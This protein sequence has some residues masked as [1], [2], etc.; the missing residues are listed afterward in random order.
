MSEPTPPL[1]RITLIGPMRVEHA[2]GAQ[3]S[4]RYEKLKA[5][6][7]YLI[8]H[9][10]QAHPRAEL[11]RLLWPDGTTEAA[12]NNLRRALFDLRK[13]FESLH[14]PCPL[15]SDRRVVQWRTTAEVHVE[16]FQV[17]H[18]DAH[19]V[20]LENVQLD[21]CPAWQQWRQQQREQLRQE[22]LA[23]LDEQVHRCERRG[24]W[25]QAIGFAELRVNASPEHEAGH[26]QL[27]RLL[28]QHGQRARAKVA[29]EACLAMQQRHWGLPL[30]EQTL[31]LGRALQD[32][33]HVVETARVRSPITLLVVHLAAQD[34]DAAGSHWHA[35]RPL[36]GGRLS[37]LSAR[38][39]VVSFGGAAALEHTPQRAW[40]V[41]R[42]QLDLDA[43]QSSATWQAAIA[44]GG[45]VLAPGYPTPD[46]S[47]QV[48]SEALAL[49]F[50]TPMG[51]M[52]LNAAALLMLKRDLPP[53]PPSIG[54]RFQALSAL[55]PLRP[56]ASFC[57][58]M[59]D[60]E[61]SPVG[62][63][64][65]VERLRAWWA[66]GLGQ[67]SRRLH[68]E[69]DGGLGKTRLLRH[70]GAH[71]IGQGGKVLLIQ[72]D[73]LFRHHPW[74]ALKQSVQGQVQDASNRP[75]S[76]RLRR[77]RRAW[78]G[79]L[80]RQAETW[81]G[82]TRLLE[83]PSTLDDPLISA[84]QQRARMEAGLFGLL[85]LWCGDLPLLLIVEDT[86]WL[87]EA[88]WQAVVRL[89]ERANWPRH[90]KVVSSARTGEGQAPTQ[91]QLT[92]L[93][94]T[95]AAANE[96]AHQLVVAAD[97]R[98]PEDTLA[99]L[100]ARA[101]GVPLF[102]EQLIHAHQRA[103]G[104][105]IAPPPTLN[106]LLLTR[107][108]GLGAHLALVQSA[109]CT[110]RTIDLTLLMHQQGT[111]S[112]QLQLGLESLQRAGI[113]QCNGEHWSFR[114]AFIQAAAHASMPD[115]VRRRVHRQLA[116]IM[117]TRTPDR[118]RE[119]PERL[120]QHLHEAGSPDAPAA[121][122]AAARH[123]NRRSEPD[124]AR[125]H[126][127]QGLDALPLLQDEA[128]RQ[129][130]AFRLWVERGHTLVALNG[131]GSE[132]SRGAYATALAMADR[133]SDEGDLFQLMWGLW[134]GSR[135][136]EEQAPPMSFAERLERA[137]RDSTDPGI[138][139]QVN[140]A[141]GNNHFWL[142][143]YPAARGR[144]EAAVALSSRVD[145]TQ[146][147]ALYGEAS[148]VCA[149]A[150][151]SWLDWLEG[152]TEKALWRADDAVA[153]GRRTGH[154][155]TLCFALAFS[156]TLQ[157]Y[158]DRADAAAKQAATLA[159]LASEHRLGLW[160][161]TAAAVAGWAQARSGDPAGLA[162]IRTG[163]A[164]AK[165]AMAAVETTFQAFLA[166]ALVHLRQWDEALLVIDDG[167]R[168][169]HAIPDTYLLP[170]L[171]RL[172]AHAQAALDPPD[173]AACEATLQAAQDIAEAQGAVA[174][175]RKLAL[176]RRV[177]LG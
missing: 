67:G 39:L 166:D 9:P 162:P 6:L 51:H 148:H 32:A 70:L 38:L 171:M 128:T 145:D 129:D 153:R 137:A 14:T 150:F 116:D 66:D 34:P 78:G 104:E 8:C 60:A 7:A 119:A 158:L 98:I 89:S 71:C 26:R 43:G 173:K 29:Y 169:A 140:Y 56:N 125:H 177:L 44:H 52:Q 72:A 127:Q 37:R 174:L 118:I 91:D 46:A 48:L 143:Q 132:S 144:L 149:Q 121:W 160:Q 88:T 136:V 131:Y 135:T 142:A 120:A 83:L 86:H 23:N 146:M 101:E 141:F 50:A 111:S 123:F 170:E 42:R 11:A 31:A 79:A 49:A 134:L 15:S 21:D 85:K 154:A 108:Q 36:L 75:E 73:P 59:S 102:L 55:P 33:D 126:L 176:S 124:A 107:M 19:G 103:H 3:A 138:H 130:M 2:S 53:A 90:W 105:R 163:L 110:G 93:P 82:L 61:T 167:L 155:H 74:Q 13:L 77:L 45:T 57:P 172:R 62:R 99:E 96:L 97:M 69:G 115:D 10:S 92:L 68:V 157:R 41:L 64:K 80:K 152:D 12:L 94:L 76:W 28:I 17:V 164:G 65:E 147:I 159:A 100:A 109:A 20:F 161:A 27:I 113:V 139:L 112:L 24:E 95:P 156:A 22:R 122:L 114:H 40:E 58:W 30:D 25:E 5:L 63:D 18:P 106:E 151:L 54:T 84:D 35:D 168:T 175:S 165:Q 133:L 1:V 16:P 4:F 47:G 87:D 117:R 81:D